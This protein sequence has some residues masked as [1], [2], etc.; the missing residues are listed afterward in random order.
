MRLNAQFPADLVTFT[1]DIYNGKLH[2]LCSLRSISPYSVRMRENTDQN[3]SE[4][5]HILRSDGN[6]RSYSSGFTKVVLLF[7]I[8]NAKVFAKTF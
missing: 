4:Y 2:F 3:N 1:E 8:Y 7:I 6:T 5:G